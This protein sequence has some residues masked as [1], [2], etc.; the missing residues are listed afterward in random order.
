MTQCW[1][2]QTSLSQSFTALPLFCSCDIVGCRLGCF[3]SA[4]TGLHTCT[5]YLTP[6]FKHRFTCFEIVHIIYESHQILYSKS[7]IWFILSETYGVFLTINRELLDTPTFW[8]SLRHPEVHNAPQHFMLV[9]RA[10]SKANYLRYHTFSPNASN[11]VS[12]NECVM[13][14][15]IESHQTNGPD[16]FCTAISPNQGRRIVSRYFSQQL[17]PPYMFRAWLSWRL[18]RNTLTHLLMSLKRVCPLWWQIISIYYHCCTVLV[19]KVH[20]YLRMTTCHPRYARV[21]PRYVNTSGTL[22]PRRLTTSPTTTA[23]LLSDTSRAI[24]LRVAYMLT[25]S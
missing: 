23:Q 6:A 11:P 10:N 1:I 25:M 16:Y 19:L 21:N 12:D 20:T 22:P 13:V 5:H 18:S 24:P 7:F 17:Q 8:K 3:R 4:V 2:H 9:C 15:I 14:Y